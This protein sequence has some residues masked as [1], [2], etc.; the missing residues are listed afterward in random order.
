MP[1]IFAISITTGMVGCAAT[2]SPRDTLRDPLD[3]ISFQAHQQKPEPEWLIHEAAVKLDEKP[4]LENEKPLNE[5]LKNNLN[6][7]ALLSENDRA[8]LLKEASLVAR[9]RGTAKCSSKK[10]PVA[11]IDHSPLA[12]LCEVRTQMV[13]LKKQRKDIRVLALHDKRLKRSH[14]TGIWNKALRTGNISA[15][16]GASDFE[17]SSA[18]K[19][20]RS[21]SDLTKLVT[22]LQAH[23]ACPP[24]AVLSPLAFKFEE[25]FPDPEAKILAKTFYERALTCEPPVSAARAAYRLGMIYVWDREFEKA[26]TAFTKY[27]AMPEFTDYRSRV[28][29]WRQFIAQQRNDLK[30]RDQLRADLKKEFPLSLHQLVIQLEQVDPKSLVQGPAPRVLF[31]SIL[32]PEINHKLRLAE[33]LQT[34]NTPQGFDLSVDALET[35]S[36]ALRDAEPE[37]QLYSSVLL[38]RAGDTL[39]KFKLLSGLFKD[40]PQLIHPES[41][42]LMFPLERLDTLRIHGDRANPILMM[43][44]IR[45]ESAF[46]PKAKSRVGALGLMQVMPKT[47]RRLEA[48]S[49][50]SLIEPKTNIRIGV[51][52]FSLLQS[53][54]SGETELSLAAYN[55]GPERVDSWKQRYPVDNRL[56]FVDLIP[57]RETREY[58]ASIA[59][60]YYFYATLYP[61]EVREAGAEVPLRNPASS[62]KVSLF[63]LFGG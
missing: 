2:P 42:G 12:W 21:P 27:F 43:S 50:K 9:A 48:V 38:T 37:V 26:D 10:L 60:N 20:I 47:A 14:A 54:Y 41:L 13:Q 35:V 58:V 24:A 63:K 25:R 5:V 32:K 49:K 62:N 3:L 4:F 6:G 1:Q 18:L 53:R 45:Q 8:I 31:K 30:L 17:I 29:Y 7:L 59:R 36:E 56:L 51:R 40:H 11:D 39:L 55:A 57:F 46:N 52:F 28:L 16:K 22:A 61:I 19:K 15:L 23:P 44:L 33:A 34:Q